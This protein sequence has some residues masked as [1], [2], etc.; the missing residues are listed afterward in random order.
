MINNINFFPQLAIFIDNTNIYTHIINCYQKNCMFIY[1]LIF[2]NY[3]CKYILFLII[4]YILS[5]IP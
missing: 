4:Y 2:L 5:Y 3:L 1:I